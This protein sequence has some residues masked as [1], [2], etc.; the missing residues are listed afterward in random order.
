MAPVRSRSMRL[1]LEPTTRF[2]PT[3]SPPSGLNSP[4]SASSSACRHSGSAWKTC[5]STARI[6]LGKT[7]VPGAASFAR[8]AAQPM[9]SSAPAPASARAS[10]LS[11]AARA[12]MP[13]TRRQALSLSFATRASGWARPVTARASALI[14]I[15]RPTVLALIPHRGHISRSRGDCLRFHPNPLAN[16][17]GAHNRT[18]R[19][20]R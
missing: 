14:A 6:S 9:L 16:R 20:V 1:S 13:P 2:T 10:Q 17:T 15:T 8:P 11:R 4:A 7:S 19:P 12:P 5:P 3:M 18:P